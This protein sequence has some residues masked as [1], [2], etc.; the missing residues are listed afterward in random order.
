MHTSNKK[1]REWE[2]LVRST[3]C[4]VTGRTDNVQIHHVVGRKG[5]HNKVHIGGVYILPLN[6]DYHM[7]DG[8]HPNAW[9]KNKKGFI[10]EFGSPSILWYNKVLCALVTNEYT[11]FVFNDHSY[12][13]GS[14]FGITADIISSI[15]DCPV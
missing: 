9:H 3:G 10:E 11:D 14:Q 4:C 6:R 12:V 2:E 5:K 1:L 15:M 8:K 13:D 7:L